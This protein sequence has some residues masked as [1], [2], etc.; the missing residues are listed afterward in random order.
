M[1][2]VIENK[3]ICLREMTVEDLSN[4]GSILKDEETMYAYE[5]SFTD[6][7]VNS[8]FE[9]NLKSYQ[10]HGFGLWAVIDKVT[11]QFVGQCG[12]VFSDVEGEQLLEVG[13]LLNK[14]FWGKGYAREASSLCLDYA[15]K[16]GAPKVCSIIRETN[17][18]SRRVA[19]YNQM[20]V[21]HEY[22]KDYSGTAVKHLVY[23][24]NFE[25]KL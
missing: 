6:K 20:L 23:S 1:A 12:L 17:L 14:Q 16:L 15:R 2:V 24:I 22:N 19:E 10:E 9:W 4:L 25:R 13:Y 11:N 7:Q 21:V 5:A 3:R 18:S 8:W